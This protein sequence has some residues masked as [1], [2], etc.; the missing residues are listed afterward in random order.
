MKHINDF[1]IRGFRGLQNLKIEKL[2]QVNLF[3]GNNNSGKTSAL[4]AAFILCD[5][6]NPRTWYEAGSQ[7]ELASVSPSVTDRLI[8]FF[9]GGVN[10]NT[11]LSENAKISFA[12]SG[13]LPIKK[14]SASYEKYTEIVKVPSSR[15]DEGTILIEEREREIEIEGIKIHISVTP[16]YLQPTLFEED[17]K[18][19]IQ[20]TLT[21]SDQRPIPLSLKK[22]RV[23]RLPSQIVNPFTHRTSRLTAQL[24]SEVVEADLKLE[25]IEL[26]RFFDP[27]IQDVDFISPTERRQLISIKHEKLGR[28]PLYTFGDGLRRV[29]ALAAT[30]PRVKGGLLLID[31]LETAIHTKALEKTFDWLVNACINNNVQLFA[32]THSLEALDTILEVSLKKVDLV[33]YRLH[34]D[35]AQTTATRFDKEMTLQLRQ[36]LGME[37]R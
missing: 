36:E 7:R 10:D 26:L 2:G 15:L 29:F 25:T 4:E 20:D 8:W 1:T 19:T 31:E 11:S 9:P 30:I 6:L 24:W 35:T 33:V 32:T 14:M 18:N 34:Q 5:P 13:H 37:M 12:A 3:V 28:T 21:F 17:L 16:R 27:A 23:S 22:P